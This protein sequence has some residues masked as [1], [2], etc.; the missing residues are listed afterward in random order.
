MATTDTSTT[1]YEWRTL[2]EQHEDLDEDDLQYIF[3]DTKE[4]YGNQ[5]PGSGFYKDPES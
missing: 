2:V 5:N 1:T 4:F 3:S